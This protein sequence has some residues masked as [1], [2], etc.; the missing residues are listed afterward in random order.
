MRVHM[1]ETVAQRAPTTARRT[2]R[3]PG[4]ARWP[5]RSPTSSALRA[6]ASSSRSTSSSDV[7][8]RLSVLVG[9]VVNPPVRFVKTIGDAAML[10]SPEA[11]ALLEALLDLIDAADEEG[12]EFPQ[13]RAGLTYGPVLTR[14]GDWFGRPVNL[15]SRDHDDRARGQRARDPRRARRR[16]ATLRS[17][18]RRPAPRRVRGVPE[19]VSLY[20]ARRAAADTDRRS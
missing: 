18:G 2:A 19:P 20:R 1:R 13:L 6:S 7:A 17:T 11:P 8:N 3:F 14:G 9:D 5:S 4:R 16:C 12:E 10:V 15:A